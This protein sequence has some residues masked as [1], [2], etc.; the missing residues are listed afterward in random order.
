TADS[1]GRLERLRQLVREAYGELT[2][3]VLQAILADHQGD[4]GGICRHGAGGS[5]S[6]AGYIAQPAAG[7]FHV[8]RGHGCTGS[9]TTYEV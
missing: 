4:P 5:H 2:V 8:R 9:W 7:L 3:E 6:V 1:P